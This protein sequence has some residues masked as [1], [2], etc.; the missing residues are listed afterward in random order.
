MMRQAEVFPTTI[1]VTPGHTA[2][3]DLVGPPA[4]RAE[5]V[6]AAQPAPSGSR[7]HRGPRRHQRSA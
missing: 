7:R 4:P 2:I 1:S 6:V 3:R 5:R